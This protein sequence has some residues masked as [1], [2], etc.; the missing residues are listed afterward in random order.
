MLLPRGKVLGGSSSIN[1][2][3]YIR[4][5]RHDYDQWEAEGCSGWSYDDVLPYFLKSEDIEIDALKNS[6]K[7]IGNSKL[8]Y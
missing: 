5:N 3:I 4:G 6:S 8:F 7:Y 2:M 1:G